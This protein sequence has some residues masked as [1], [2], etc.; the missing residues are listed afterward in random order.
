MSRPSDLRLIVA[1]IAAVA[2]V[3]AVGTAVVIWYGSSY[4][5]RAG[6]LR[7][8]EARSLCE[9]EIRWDTGIGQD[10]PVDTVGAYAD[11]DA[12]RWIVEAEGEREG[13]RFRC[14]VSGDQVTVDPVG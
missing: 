6:G 3:L 14:L 11:Q 1:L 13:E 10:T 9:E 12:D 2:V 7:E 8:V 5:E 4:L